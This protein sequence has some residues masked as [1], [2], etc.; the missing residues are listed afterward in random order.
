MRLR[1]Y[2]VVYGSTCWC[3]VAC[4]GW[5]A[6]E[7]EDDSE[8]GLRSQGGGFLEEV[9]FDPPWGWGDLS[10]VGLMGW[11]VGVG[12]SEACTAEGCQHLSFSPS[13]PGGCRPDGGAGR[14]AIEAGSI[15]SGWVLPHH[16]GTA[17]ASL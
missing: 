10:H 2:T 17:G 14:V 3:V 12:L 6:L 8:P 4:R 16:A 11:W 9:F 1:W 5:G 13:S 15:C 7:R